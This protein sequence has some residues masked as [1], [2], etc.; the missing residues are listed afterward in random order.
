MSDPTSIYTLHSRGEDLAVFF[1]TFRGEIAD[2]LDQHGAVLVRGCTAADVQHFQQAL[3]HLGFAPLQYTERSTP[4]SEVADGVFTST[5]Y[6]AREV[7]PQHCESSYSDVWPGRLAFFCVTPPETGGAT[8]IAD[9]SAVLADVPDAVVTTMHERG[10]RYVRNY[11]GGVGLDWR[12]AFQTSDRGEVE[13]FCR[14]HALQWQWLD[15]DCLRTVRQAPALA[16]HPRTGVPVW[17]NHLVLFHQS[18]LAPEVRTGLVEVLGADRLPNDVLYGDG[19]TIPDEAV[20][21]VRAAFARHTQRFDWERN[22]LMVVDNMRWSHGREAFTGTRRIVVSM[23]DA[24]T[25]AEQPDF[26]VP[27]RG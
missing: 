13:R 1:D 25:R 17:F 20:D 10:L 2:R 6:P 26:A 19:E 3:D 15:D 21:A 4:R 27:L 11:G 9:V 14:D 12:T 16:V 8:P 5:E 7:I 24:L 18:A 22:D 23:S